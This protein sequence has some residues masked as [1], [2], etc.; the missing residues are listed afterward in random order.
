MGRDTFHQT[1]L[2][3]ALSNLALNT[4]RER[5]AT[6]SL[7]NLGQCLTTL[8]EF[9]PSI[10]SNLP[11]FSLKPLL[12]VPWK[13]SLSSFLVGLFR[14]WK[15][16]IRFLWSL[17]QAEQPQLSQPFLTEEVFQP[18]DQL[19]ALLWT[20][21]NRSMSVL[22]WGLQSWTQDSQWSLTRAE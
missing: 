14:C 19:C 16:A 3:K 9:L 7:G 4:A 18:S 10:W 6:A 22:C 8:K 2:L 17:L 15:A 12:L 11:S 13:K 21:S 5:A 20:H 1:R